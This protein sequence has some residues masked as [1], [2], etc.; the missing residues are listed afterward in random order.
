MLT[1]NFCP[2]PAMTPHAGSLL[3]PVL[4]W[5]PVNIWHRAEDV[6]S[7]VTKAVGKGVGAVGRAEGGGVGI[8]G[9]I[10]GLGLGTVLGA[11]VGFALVGRSVGTELGA[12]DAPTVGTR[13]GAAVGE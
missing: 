12:R 7:D 3:V 6:G 11:A 1:V 9:N 10:V 5:L 4:V 8:P 13:T 2:A